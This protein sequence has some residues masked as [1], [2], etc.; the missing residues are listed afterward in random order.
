[1]R[2]LTVNPTPIPRYDAIS[3]RM[4]KVDYSIRTKKASKPLLLTL[5][6]NLKATGE[7][8]ECQLYHFVGRTWVDPISSK[9]SSF[10]LVRLTS[11]SWPPSHTLSSTYAAHRS[12]I[13]GEEDHCAWE[14]TWNSCKYVAVKLRRE[15]LM[16]NTV[17]WRGL[18]EDHALLHCGWNIINWVGQAIPRTLAYLTT[19]AGIYIHTLQR[20]GLRR[21][22]SSCAWTHPLLV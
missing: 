8:R 7:N 9:S 14:S 11:T 22:V 1:M 19:K 10:I 5:W 12:A 13:E 16:R 3:T 2:K 4:I 6:G 21:F 15:D 17:S 20:F 18:Y